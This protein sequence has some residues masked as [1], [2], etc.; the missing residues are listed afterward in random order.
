[1]ETA[2]AYDKYYSMKHITTL[3]TILFITLLSSPS[4]GLSSQFVCNPWFY[5]DGSISEDSFLLKFNNQTVIV[6]E[7]EYSLASE[8]G[9]SLVYIYDKGYPYVLFVHDGDIGFLPKELIHSNKII[10]I[11]E[12]ESPVR[13]KLVPLTKQTKC[14]KVT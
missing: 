3:A 11:T 4:W 14:T 8:G 9:T 13:D 12:V 7:T 6:A 10:F 2:N 5:A 1:M